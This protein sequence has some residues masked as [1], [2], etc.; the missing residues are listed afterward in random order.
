MTTHSSIL[1]WKNTTDR[2]VCTPVHRITESQTRLSKHI[3]HA[4]PRVNHNV[5]YVLW[6]DDN[7]S[8]Q[9]H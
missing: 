9:V 2:G 4:I 1:P 6:G 3:Q 8:V 5:K 7:V